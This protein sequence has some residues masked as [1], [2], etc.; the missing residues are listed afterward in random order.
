[1]LKITC[2]S[3]AIVGAILC[4]IVMFISHW[5]FALLAIAIGAIMYKYIEYKG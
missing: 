5:K 2:R 4:I 1:M 3:T